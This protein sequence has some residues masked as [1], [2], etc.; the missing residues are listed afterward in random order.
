MAT[1]AAIEAYCTEQL[2]PA[3]F[4]DYCPNGLQV[5]AGEKIQRIVSGVT[6]SLAIIKAAQ[7]K[8]ADMLL[9]HHGYFWKGEPSQL[10]GMKG[11]RIQYL[12]QSG[13]SLIAYH[14]P[15]DAHP[16]FGNNACL[17]RR[18]SFSGKPIA[19]KSLIWGT[20]L[21]KPISATNITERLQKT[22]QRTPTVIDTERPI[23]RI[24]WCTGGAQ[25][26]IEQAAA[27]G[28]DAYISGE[29]SEK[30]QHQAQELGISYFAAGHHATERYGVQALGE[31]LAK[32]FSLEHT[33]IDSDNPA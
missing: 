26:Y 28:Y 11:R 29:I 27:F 30:T 16:T 7:A 5:E 19:P 6:A 15:L 14:L 21:A 18:L 2:N 13:I 12:M 31:Q 3:A 24:A 20:T 17:G 10:I 32:Q 23:R 33:F 9:V 8:Q 1:L 4:D 25:S 22:L